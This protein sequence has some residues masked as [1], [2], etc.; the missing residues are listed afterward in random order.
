MTGKTAKRAKRSND[1]RISFLG[2]AGEIGK[3]MT[4]FECGED[5]IIVDAGLAFAS[6]ED[7]PG[8]D[9]LIPDFEYVKANEKRLKA[10]FITHGHEDHIGAMPF[11][12]KEV[13]AP[14]YGGAMSI[15]LIR[16]KL[17][18]SKVK[19][20]KLC[21]VEDRQVVS[22]GRF[23][24]EFVRVA[25]SAV[26]SYALHIVW[27]RGSAFFTGDFKLDNSPVDGKRTDLRRIAEI[28]KK[29]VLAML[30]DSTN[31]DEAGFGMS[32][33]AVFVALDALF[34]ARPDRR[35]IVPVFASHVHRVRQI[36]D[37]AT[38]HGRKFA[39][40]GRSMIEI[41]E[42]A[43]NLGELSYDKADEVP[44]ERAHDFAKSE[45]C[46]ICT[47]TQGEPLSVLGRLCRGSVK[48][49]KI[50]EGDSVI[51]SSSIIPG[52]EKDVYRAANA[53]CA[54]GAEVLLGEENGIHA[55]GHARREE[56][57]LMLSLVMPKYF[58]PVHG[59]PR[60]LAR[61]KGLAIEVGIP[62]ENVFVPDNGSSIEI[63][64]KGMKKCAPVPFGARCV[65]DRAISLRDERTLAARKK[66]AVGG[67]V[68]IR[69]D[70][71]R[72]N[73]RVF[74]EI[75]TRGLEL[76]AAQIAELKL[77]FEQALIGGEYK[78]L[79]A[80]SIRERVVRV[81]LKKLGPRFRAKPEIVC[82][83]GI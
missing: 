10:I 11:L 39:L 33:A 25:H 23:S 29:G 82:S 34:A 64:P 1:V 68:F 28:G 6:F 12:L 36:I 67:V 15:G 24:V 53:L 7:A 77:A 16:R 37:C 9:A 75:A 60:H 72:D 51:F 79:S 27:P 44:I 45:I 31:A 70:G 65:V 8:A 21:V 57:K 3:N 55:S 43:R 62:A 20:A 2:G 19:N 4:V 54:L 13:K 76:D 52:N 14:A 42:L 46:V 66:M 61:H 58:I 49:L 22:A 17:E 50:G 74:V 38:R 30:S 81:A 47:G 40:A 48:K 69:L 73:S 18:E 59:E 71:V 83:P 32:E 41:A 63:G 80:D 26:G 5:M 78:G 35:I 56:L